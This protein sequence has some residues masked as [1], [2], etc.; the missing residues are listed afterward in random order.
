[1]SKF[2]QGRFHP[3]NPEKYIGDPNNIIY[4]SSWELHFLQ[5]CDRTE[6]VIKYASEEFSIKYVSP[7]DNRV[8]RYYPDGYIIYKDKNGVEKKCIIE[9]KP[10]RQT[11]E[12]K[13]P[14]RQT[15]T[16]IN[17]MKTYLLNQAKW[18]YASEFCKDNGVE[19]RILTENELGIKP[20]G[21]PRTRKVS[22][23]KNK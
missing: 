17:E 3:R 21:R 5:W 19:F 14:E 7:L 8:H 6:N 16:Y 20:Y 4:R 15:K 1:M 23:K 9:I 10:Y 12:P 2:H 18:K 13:V 22:K 11:Q